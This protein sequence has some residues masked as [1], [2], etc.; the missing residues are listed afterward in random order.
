MLLTASAGGTFT[1][2]ESLLDSLHLPYNEV[3]LMPTFLSIGL[4]L[5]GIACTAVAFRP[6]S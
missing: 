4:L 6:S 1:R 5:L 3:L 2:G